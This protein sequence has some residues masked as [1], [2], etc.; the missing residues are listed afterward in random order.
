MN[1]FKLLLND[2]YNN[3]KN[4]TSLFLSAFNGSIPSNRS[5]KIKFKFMYNEQHNQIIINKEINLNHNFKKLI[6]FISKKKCNKLYLETKSTIEDIKK[7]IFN[8]PNNLNID[9]ENYDD[10]DYYQEL[11][12][13]IIHCIHILR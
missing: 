8:F 5:K 13:Y 9:N 6:E 7:I 4:A 11:F 3:M 2:Y 1:C 10:D 12:K